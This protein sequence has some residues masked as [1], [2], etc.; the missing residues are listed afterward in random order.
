MD[1]LTDLLTRSRARGAAFARTRARGE[2]GIAFPAVPGPTLHTVLEG[3]VAFWTR[4]PT[5]SL[6]LRA[7]DD[8]PHRPRAPTRAAGPADA[9]RPAARRRTR[10][11]P[12]RALHRQPGHGAGMVP[13]LRRPPPQPRAARPPRESRTPL[14]GRGTGSTRVT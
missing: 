13:R 10:P 5:D 2:W 14:D 9:A 6:A 11:D 12:A 7:R 1:V 8:R 4:D 3:E